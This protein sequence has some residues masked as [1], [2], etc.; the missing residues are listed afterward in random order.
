MDNENRIDAA[1][2]EA[3]EKPDVQEFY[4]ELVRSGG[5]GSYSISRLRNERIRWCIWQGRTPDYKKHKEAIGKEP[6]PWENAWDGRV[7]VA[8]GIIE[9]LVVVALS[10][11]ARAKVK[12]VPTN[13]TEIDRSEMIEKVVAK[14][15]D[16]DKKRI[17]EEIGYLAQF[18]LTYGGS[19]MQVSWERQ[20]RMKYV[21]VDMAA[22]NQMAQ[23]TKAKMADPA[24]QGQVPP[25]QQMAMSFFSRL[26]D[27]I[28]DET[29]EEPLAKAFIK[30]AE[31]LAGAMMQSL[32][33]SESPLSE[34]TLPLPKARK[35]V[36]DLREKGL[37]KIPVPYIHRNAPF[38]CARQAGYDYFCPV[39]MTQLDTAAWHAVRETVTAVQLQER[40]TVEGWD[41]GW[42]DEVKETKGKTLTWNLE[43][44]TKDTEPDDAP[45]QFNV[46]NGAAKGQLIELIYHYSRVLNDDGVP[47]I[48]CTIYSPH[49]LQDDKGKAAW[50]DHYVTDEESGEYGFVDYRWKR[51]QRPFAS[52]YGLPELVGSDQQQIKR[53]LDQLEDRKDLEVNPAWM[54]KTR[55]GMKYKSGP[56]SQIPRKAPGDIEPLPAPSGDP[57][58]AFELIANTLLRLA[59]YFGL[60]REGVLPAQW[61]AK[62]QDFVN[63]FLS[64]VAE[65]YRRYWML[66]QANITTEE[67]VAIAGQDPQMPKSPEEIQGQHDFSLQFDVKDLDVEVVWKKLQA[68][69]QTAVPIDRAGIIDM[70]VLVKLILNAIDP[71]LSPALV[72]SK[73]G[74]SKQLLDKVKQD[75]AMMYLG[76]EPEYVENDPTAE[77]KLQFLREVIY[78][79]GRGNGGNPKYQQALGIVP[80]G[81]VDQRFIELVQNYQKNLQMS[82][83]QMQVNPGVGRTGVQQIGAGNPAATP[84]AA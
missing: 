9:E 19:V 84:Q 26:P 30:Y 62:L 73:Q 24:S 15:L 35:I 75:V 67:L 33:Y 80:G 14:Y 47:V 29:Y 78:G 6:V 71:S 58:L 60:M 8:D 79:D 1:L 82:I 5:L 37:A 66:I 39:E 20:V 18:S 46:L 70:S 56:G 42:V 12:I 36:R 68:I 77:S 51:S 28:M 40:A 49:Y 83:T 63:N 50:A 64:A 32:S 3:T 34:Y 13:F 81:Q 38:I 31:N 2:T 55:L 7:R 41:Q 53:T 10:A 16:R 61:Q 52:S 65:I 11:F 23:A 4:N 43:A 21:R 72:G 57:K 54:V 17:L 76:N 25:D 45:E 27:Q 48:Y 69:L 74:A 22:I 44:A 59:I